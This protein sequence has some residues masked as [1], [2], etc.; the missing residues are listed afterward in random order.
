MLSLRSQ[1]TQKILGHF[2]LHEGNAMYVNEMC[3][4]LDVD[5]G[6]LIKKLKELEGEGVLKSEWKGNQ[7][8]Y[9]LNPSFPLLKEYKK[10]ILK[11][12][13]FEHILRKTL[14][15]VKG[16]RKAILFGSY[17]QDRMNL[18]SDID[19]LAIGTHSTIDLQ[20]KIAELQKAVD[21][22]INVISMS[23]QEYERKRKTDSLLKS[24]GKRK[25]IPIL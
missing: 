1:V 12:V 10:I 7:R 2:F 3:R 18:S 5:R 20:K 9:F 21:R 23:P 15:E 14:Q 22:E 25:S 6:N 19:L 11:T 16:L 17:A 8:Y 13:G 4:R 24:I